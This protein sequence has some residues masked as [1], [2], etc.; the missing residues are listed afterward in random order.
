[1]AR[2]TTGSNATSVLG[3]RPGDG[4]KLLHFG[5]ECAQGDV[6]PVGVAAESAADV[7]VA[8]AFATAHNIRVA[9]KSSGHD[10]QGRSTAASSLLIWMARMRN[11]TVLESFAACE[12]DA[13][14]A[15]VSAAPGDSYGELYALLDPERIVVGGSARTVSAAGGHLLG[16]GH[17]FVS[18]H[19]GLAVDNILS[20]EVVL[21]NA[22]VVRAS[23][24]ENSDLF[25]ALRGGGGASFGVLTG[26][27]HR[28]HNTP[29]AVSGVFFE[30]A[31]LQGLTSANMW[32]D[33]ALALTPALLDASVNVGGGVF[34]GYHN[35]VPVDSSPGVFVW[36]SIWNFNSTVDN[37]RASLAGFRA[38]VASQPLHFVLVNES[39]A[40]YDSFEQWHS[41][42]DPP[43]TGDRTGSDSTIGCRFV[44]L[45]FARDPS[46]RANASAALTSVLQYVPLLGHLVAGGAVAAFDR[47]STQTSVSPAWRD[48]VWHEC[49]GAGWGLSANISAQD[50]VIAGV[51]ELTETWRALLTPSGAYF[52]EADLLEPLWEESFFGSANY[53]RLQMIKKDVDPNGVFSCWHCVELP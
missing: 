14:V 51:S 36:E 23:A 24:C 10:I 17:S 34:G 28:L 53:A 46:L 47:D 29:T 27:V 22:T 18:P 19:F 2:R 41:S 35:V 50:S 52:N 45:S 7:A 16:G 42:F 6:P 38:L 3:V 13:P 44:P 5:R 37:M 21:A 1:M 4:R 43:D 39:Y 32:L 33:G 9:V 25:W 15:A 30:V 31:L 48:A 26:V 12:G 40:A 20:A 8:V 49:I 11:V